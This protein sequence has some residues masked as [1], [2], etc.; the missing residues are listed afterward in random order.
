MTRRQVVAAAI[1]D[2]L[3]NPTRLLTAQRA[4]PSVLAGGWELPGGKV[5]PGET[6]I[7][8][9]HRE[10]GEE[11]A[12]CVRLGD[13]VPGPLA[14]PAGAWPLGDEFALH[15]W[16]AQIV[17]GA[18]HFGP[19]HQDIRWLSY[20]TLDEVRWLRDDRPVVAAVAPR[21]IADG[22]SAKGA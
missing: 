20:E 7:E 19:E 11:L 17:A 10:I 4:E 14:Q 22:R 18:P 15:V 9:L 8:A 5:E 13:F 2:D 3:K 1:V 16:M 12:V 21:L 6:A